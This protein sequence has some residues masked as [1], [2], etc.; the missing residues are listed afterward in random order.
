MLPIETIV[1]PLD[2][3][4]NSRQALKAAAEFAEELSARLILIHVVPPVPVSADTP[5]VTTGYNAPVGLGTFN[6]KEYIAHLRKDAEEKL[7]GTVRE[8]VPDS[9]D[10]ETAVLSGGHEADEINRF[11]E[12]RDA[13]MIIISTHG[14]TGLKRLFFGSVAEKVIRQAEKPVLTIRSYSKERKQKGE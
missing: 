6:V 7:A 12:K 4:E 3:S 2:F 9:V 5:P 11:A 10:S 8:Q 14:R 1:C 13:D